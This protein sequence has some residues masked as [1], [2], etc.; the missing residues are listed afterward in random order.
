VNLL[1]FVYTILH[2]QIRMHFF[3]GVA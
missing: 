2:H 3:S 1:H